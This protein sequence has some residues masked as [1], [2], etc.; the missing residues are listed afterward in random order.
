MRCG[1]PS[2]AAHF[3][4][5]RL[6]DEPIDVGTFHLGLF[7]HT[8]TFTPYLRLKSATRRSIS[9]VASELYKVSVPS[10]F[11]AS[12]KNLP[13]WLSRPDKKEQAHVTSAMFAGE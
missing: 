8:S 13:Q 7:R 9:V 5:R 10:F 1:L 12:S 4:N 6:R 3:G 11:A 2:H